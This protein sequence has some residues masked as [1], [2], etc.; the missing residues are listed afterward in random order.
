MKFFDFENLEELNALSDV[1]KLMLNFDPNYDPTLG[2]RKNK[3]NGNDVKVVEMPGETIDLRGNNNGE[4]NF[5]K[6][7]VKGTNVEIASSVDV[8]NRYVSEF[9]ITAGFDDSVYT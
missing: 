8:N 1:D 9:P 7:N 4:T 5:A 2:M 3:K 6:S